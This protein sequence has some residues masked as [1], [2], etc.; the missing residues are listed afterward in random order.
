MGE[1]VRLPDEMYHHGIKGQKWGQRH[2]QN[3]DGSLTP[4]GR[5]RYGQLLKKYSS[6]KSGLSAKRKK[7]NSNLD[8]Q[9]SR[10]RLNVKKIS[11]LSK[12]LSKNA[13]KQAKIDKRI[14]DLDAK[15]GIKKT[16]KTTTQMQTGFTKEQR[17][18]IEKTYSRKR[19]ALMAKIAL[20]PKG[21]LDSVY[22]I[23]L[24]RLERSYRRYLRS[25]K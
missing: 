9:L 3:L 7:L 16:R 17:A 20:L 21:T 19:A 25:S 8:E 18:R 5:E 15:N 14:A 2:F 12:K 6:K 11:K 22:K 24:A 1:W 23:K 4:A 10:N 13:K